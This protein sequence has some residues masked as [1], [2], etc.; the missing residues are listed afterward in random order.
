MGRDQRDAPERLALWRRRQAP[1]RPLTR[2]LLAPRTCAT[3]A[4]PF[5]PR[6]ACPPSPRRHLRPRRA[7]FVD[8]W[9]AEGFDDKFV[10][11]NPNHTLFSPALLL[12]VDVRPHSGEERVLLLVPG[13]MPR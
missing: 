12:A 3:L 7:A 9:P 5:A 4:R 2:A 1:T 13:T 6:H 8:S 10:A 11:V